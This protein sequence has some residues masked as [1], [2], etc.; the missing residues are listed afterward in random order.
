VYTQRLDES[1]V[2]TQDPAALTGG[3]QG[4]SIAISPDG[5]VMVVSAVNEQENTGSQ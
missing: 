1:L 2:K 5:T 3:S 4:Y